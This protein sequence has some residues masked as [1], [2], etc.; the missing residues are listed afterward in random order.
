MPY[1]RNQFGEKLLIK[2][3]NKRNLWEYDSLR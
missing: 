1:N 2:F 3:M